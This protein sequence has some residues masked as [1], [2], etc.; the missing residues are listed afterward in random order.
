MPTVPPKQRLAILATHPVQY[1]KPV[2]Q[3]LAANTGI[4]LLVVFGCD[5]GVQ[6]SLDPDFGVSFA[7][8]SAPTDGF[9]HHVVSQAPLAQLS[10]IAKAWPLAQQACKTIQAFH[11]DAVLVFSYSPAFISLSL[12][13]LSFQGQRLWLRAET[14]DIAL[15]R[16]PIKD[17]TRSWVLRQLYRR[18]DH[19]F[20]IGL[21]SASHYT[22][23]GVPLAKQSLARYAVDVDFFQE[24]VN[25][26]KLRR[27][28]VRQALQIPEQ[29]HVLL[30][31]GK[32]TAVKDPLLIAKALHT[33]RRHPCFSRIQLLVVGDGELKERFENDA[34]QALPGR[35][36]FLGFQNQQQLGQFYAA[37][38]TLLLPSQS[39]ETWGLVVNEALQ[40]GCNV[41]AS[42][43]VGSGPDLLE[44]RPWGRRHPVG[45]AHALA[46]AIAE[47][48][49]E[50]HQPQPRLTADERS[51]P[52]P[53]E[54]V[55]AITQQLL[56]PRPTSC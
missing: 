32:L 29:A 33:L 38:D 5:H 52:H 43:L 45:D 17:W 22:R 20:P 16:S 10:R 37:A 24:Q 7:W 39:G 19:V 55:A 15:R 49:N 42:T 48:A 41:I 27:A 13:L 51:L 36:H 44:G 14:S 21:R 1:F 26:W 23:L 3:G 11:P 6:A 30:F 25:T 9:P 54:L 56:R 47:L 40:F 18:L 12:A 4:E 8:D 31:V 35:C 53:Q 50:E 46:Q 34:N 28:S 2:F